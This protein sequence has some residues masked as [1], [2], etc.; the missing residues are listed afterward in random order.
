MRHFLVRS[1]ILIWHS[2]Q[3]TCYNDIIKKKHHSSAFFDQVSL[4]QH[5][6]S[7]IF[8]FIGWYFMIFMVFHISAWYLT[9]YFTAMFPSESF[10]PRNPPGIPRRSISPRC[11]WIFRTP[12]SPVVGI[13]RTWDSWDPWDGMGLMGWTRG[14]D[15]VLIFPV[16]SIG[17]P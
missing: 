12:T 11:V 14:P 6:F 7:M 15:G 16:V 8:Q 1:E 9:A 10:T 17:I 5:D 2:S 4:C 3:L 13:P